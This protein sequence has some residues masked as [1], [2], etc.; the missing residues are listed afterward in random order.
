MAVVLVSVPVFVGVLVAVAME[1]VVE[2]VLV[3]VEL[4][5]V[6]LQTGEL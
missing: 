4:V 5:D 3:A 6:A 2:P 1:V